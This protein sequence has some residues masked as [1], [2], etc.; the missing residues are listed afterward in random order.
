MLGRE[1]VSQTVMNQ[2]DVSF[3]KPGIYLV[4]LTDGEKSV[5]HKLIKN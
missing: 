4:S 5:T 2:M 1:V 3:L